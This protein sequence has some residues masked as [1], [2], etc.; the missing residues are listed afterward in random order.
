MDYPR[1]RLNS[2]ATQSWSLLISIL[3]LSITFQILGVPFSFGNLGGASDLIEASHLEGFSL[4]SISGWT[5]IL[6]RLLSFSAARSRYH[7]S[8]ADA[9][10]HPPLA[11]F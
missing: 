9:I 6:E 4:I 2:S 7:Y 10:F 5:P 11:A 1:L 3:C 8:S